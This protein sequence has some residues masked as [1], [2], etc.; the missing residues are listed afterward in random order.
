MTSIHSK[1]A[2][3]ETIG[4]T[5]AIDDA[6][7]Q[8]DKNTNRSVTVN[9]DDANQS[10]ITLTDPDDGFELAFRARVFVLANGTGPLTADRTLTLPSAQQVY[11]FV[12]TWTSTGGPWSVILDAGGTTYTIPQGQKVSVYVDGSNN[13]NKGT[14]NQITIEK[15]NVVVSRDVETID[16]TGSAIVGV[17]DQGSG[18]TEVEIGAGG[19]ASSVSFNN[20]PSAIVGTDVQA[21]LDEADALLDG[22]LGGDMVPIPIV[23]P[24]GLPAA[25]PFT[26]DYGFN[27][28]YSK[29][30]IVGNGQVDTDDAFLDIE[31]FDG[32]NWTDAVIDYANTARD[33][34]NNNDDNE[35]TGGADLPLSRAG[36]DTTAATGNQNFVMTIFNPTDP[37]NWKY[38]HVIS[39]RDDGDGA[40]EHDRRWFV[41]KDTLRL[42]GIRFGISSGNLDALEFHAYGVK[43]SQAMRF[44]GFEKIGEVVET[45]GAIELVVDSSICDLTN[46]DFVAIICVAEL[47]TDT[48]NTTIFHQG[49]DDD[50]VG[51][52]NSDF[53]RQGRISSGTA[54]DAQGNATATPYVTGDVAGEELD[55]TAGHKFHHEVMWLNLARDDFYKYSMDLS[56]WGD[57][58]GTM[59][60]QV[61]EDLDP[62]DALRWKTL[63]ASAMLTGRVDVYALRKGGSLSHGVVDVIDFTEL[64]GAD[65]DN[66]T[67]MNSKTQSDDYSAI[68]CIGFVQPEVTNKTVELETTDDIGVSWEE[69]LWDRSRRGLDSGG[70]DQGGGNGSQ[71]GYAT[72]F[73]VRNTSGEGAVFSAMF[74]DHRNTSTFRSSISQ[75]SFTMDTDGDLQ[76]HSGG[77]QRQASDA[78][79]GFR[80]R[81]TDATD[82]IGYMITLG[83]RKTTT[84]LPAIVN[85]KPITHAD[86]APIDRTGTNLG[87]T[88]T[89]VQTAIVELDNRGDFLL[90]EQNP[91]T[92]QNVTLSV[93]LDHTD[94]DEFVISLDWELDADDDLILEVD[95]GG[96]QATNYEYSVESK[97]TQSNTLDID[98]TNGGTAT[99][100]QLTS[101]TAN[102]EVDSAS[103]GGVRI[104]ELRFPNMAETA[105]HKHFEWTAI[106]SKGD[107]GAPVRAEGVGT[108]VGGAGAITQIRIG[109]AGGATNISGN[110]KLKGKAKGI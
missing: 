47:E 45:A 16:F 6:T 72:S 18:E 102:W 29:I 86:E 67:V 90:E 5:T 88:A 60:G 105:Q 50:G 64:T 10:L 100:I 4:D 1:Y 87:D 8:E 44:P 103:T 55:E 19:A 68:W 89:T 23:Q 82:F 66:I 21:A 99:A 33:K 104:K 28:E 81:L 71:T 80:L 73:G 61:I 54:I 34:D 9:L 31:M 15:D 93:G 36:I 79:D 51:W 95:S 40:Q 74:P 13:V 37:T 17:T 20:E 78:L 69:A 32:T 41:W 25:G 70:T 58:M 98:D 2:S 75:T 24:T 59:G 48:A 96:F 38:G 35:A 107:D 109:A 43:K 26:L 12:S 46:P 22:S 42:Q 7:D 14:G 85:Q 97:E 49:S 110:I 62:I 39:S 53:A 91:T 52:L 63:T 92:G 56:V 101:T 11:E 3:F 76:T 77:G 84:G 106:Y 108:W 94:I 57:V 27:D 30:V 83:I 65:D